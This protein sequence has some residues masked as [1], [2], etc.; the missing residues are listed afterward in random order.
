MK[1]YKK[2]LYRIAT[3]FLLLAMLIVQIQVPFLSHAAGPTITITVAD[4]SGLGNENVSVHVSGIGVRKINETSYTAEIG[5]MVYITA[6]SESKFFTGWSF[7]QTVSGAVLAN[8]STSFTAPSGDLTINPLSRSTTAADRGKVMSDS[9]KLNSFGD[10]YALQEMIAKTSITTAEISTY[11]A[12]AQHFGLSVTTTANYA[13]ARTQLNTGYFIVQSDVALTELNPDTGDDNWTPTKFFTGIGTAAAAFQGVIDGGGHQVALLINTQLSDMTSAYYTGLLGNAQGTAAKNAVIR[14][15]KVSGSIT[16][17]V[18]FGG[19]LGYKL[20]AGGLAGYVGSNVVLADCSSKANIMVKGTYAVQSTSAIVTVGGLAGQIDANV[21]HGSNLSYN[22]K[23]LSISAESN[24]LVYA[25]GCFGYANNTYIFSAT[26]E[27]DDSKVIANSS[28]QFGGGYAL[29]SAGGLAGYFNNTTAN[30]S[31]AISEVDVIS[32]GNFTI[33]ATIHNAAGKTAGNG[34]AGGLVGYI[35]VIGTGAVMNVTDNTIHA[36]SEGLIQARDLSQDS[37]SPVY[38]GGVF[39]YTQCTALQF[40]GDIFDGKIRVESVIYGKASSYAGGLAGYTTNAPSGEITLDLTDVHVK[41][42]EKTTSSGTIHSYVGG[43]FGAA[44]ANIALSGLTLTGS[45]ILISS[46]RDSGALSTGALLSGGIIGIKDGGSISNCRAL[47]IS[48]FINVLQESYLSSPAATDPYS[49]IYAGGI[50]GYFKSTGTLTN[51]V[52]AGASDGDGGYTGTGAQIMGTQNGIYGNHGISDGYIGGIAGKSNGEIRG[53][54]YYGDPGST[55]EGIILHSNNSANSPCVAGIVGLTQHN[56]IDCHVRNA[57]IFGDGYNNDASKSDTDIIVAGV[58]G[59][60]NGSGKK[61]MNCTVDG[62]RVEASGRDMTLTYAGGIVGAFFT[63][64]LTVSGC[65]FENGEVVG[66]GHMKWG[67][68]GGILGY[69]YDNSAFVVDNCFVINSN[70]SASSAGTDPLLTPYAAAGGFIGFVAP[71]NASTAKMVITNSFSNAHLTATHVDP[72]YVVTGGIVGYRKQIF[73]TGDNLTNTFYHLQNSGADV[74]L[75][76][77]PITNTVQATITAKAAVDFSTILLDALSPAAVPFQTGISDTNSEMVTAAGSPY[78]VTFLSGSEII[79]GVPYSLRYKF[80]AIPGMY[81]FNT[82]DFVA[83]IRQSNPDN[84]GATPTIVRRTFGTI[85]VVVTDETLPESTDISLHYDSE[86]GTLVETGINDTVQLKTGASGR[87][88]FAITENPLILDGTDLHL[89]NWQ[90]YDSFG[91]PIQPGALISSGVTI[92]I[93]NNHIS[94][95]PNKPISHR[96]TFSFQAASLTDPTLKTSRVTVNVDPIYVESVALTN[97]TSPENTNHGAIDSLGTPSNP[98]LVVKNSKLI[99]DATVYGE[100]GN[101]PTISSYAFGKEVCVSGIDGVVH[102]SSDGT[103][104]TGPFTGYTDAQL[105]NTVYKVTVKSIGEKADG[106]VAESR[107]IYIRLCVGTTVDKKTSGTLAAGLVDGSS[108]TYTVEGGLIEGENISLLMW[109]VDYQFSVAPEVGYGSV[110]DVYYTFGTPNAITNPYKKIPIGAVNST[111]YGLLKP[112]SSN[113]EYNFT[114][115]AD[116]ALTQPLYIM[117]KY[118]KV[119]GVLFDPNNGQPSLV[120][121]LPIGLPIGD[122]IP[123]VSFS[124]YTFTGWYTLKQAG[125]GAAYG[126]PLS[127]SDVVHAGVVYYARWQY[128]LTIINAA[129][130]LISGPVPFDKNQNFTFSVSQDAHAAGTPV[131]NV[132]IGEKSGLIIPPVHYTL[133]TPVYIVDPDGGA[134]AAEIVVTLDANGKQIHTVTIF[135]DYINKWINSTPYGIKIVGETISSSFIPEEAPSSSKDSRILQ[136][137]SFTLRYSVNHGASASNQ[138]ASYAFRPANSGITKD[139]AVQIVDKDDNP[140]QLPAGTMIRLHYNSYDDITGLAKQTVWSYCLPEAADHFQ[141]SAFSAIGETTAFRAET[142]GAFVASHS[143]KPEEYYF[144]VVPPYQDASL[145]TQADLAFNMGFV[146]D[147]GTIIQET[148]QTVSSDVAAKR[149]VS[150]TAEAQ[151]ALILDSITGG[152]L[153]IDITF[154]NQLLAANTPIDNRDAAFGVSVSFRNAEGKSVWL[155]AGSAIHSTSP[156]RTV[157]ST[158][159]FPV[160]KFYFQASDSTLDITIPP[161]GTDTAMQNE[162]KPLLTAAPGEYE[163]VIQLVS[164]RTNL[165]Y[166]NGNVLQTIVIPVTVS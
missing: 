75:G 30:A 24:E 98:L 99:L 94:I 14:N 104:F 19:T 92:S 33:S 74:A 82:T 97:A 120:V 93:T 16:V 153:S 10:F 64:S 151:G 70:L 163:M 126:N 106:H 105:A 43:F 113:Y 69:F 63:S 57:Y 101:H 140:T 77:T 17:D 50:V 37:S 134:F 8:T 13:T 62:S 59:L 55:N 42:V 15:I 159:T 6:V 117:V 133:G 136:D 89:V 73:L 108:G 80:A 78:E 138:P 116:P 25:G 130:Q 141:T 32:A 46:T 162:N 135:S 155:P 66:N 121:N 79:N 45:N 124:G 54:S 84:A 85:A 20:A 129:G 160:E 72:S 48:G 36:G 157:T 125:S 56:V 23:A 40:G 88:F 146:D 115:K 150:L 31:A 149:D 110:P 49:N 11:N 122:A 127:A 164:S 22:A 144:V 9:F 139:L 4:G 143:F 86:T 165:Q 53:C 61:I 2:Q 147:S 148:K 96:M 137:T 38:C 1:R 60:I 145:A 107:E 142:F 71:A 128:K 83:F 119:T 154:V 111:A 44:S 41:A 68:A 58:V 26:A 81:G 21:A 100:N 112:G 67:A 27:I 87:D 52:V 12:Y 39:G 65:I 34:Y 166:G 28:G 91:N 123:T 132:S 18:S 51:S 90:F 114:I 35:K 158:L 131:Y 95:V 29:A 109:N 3:T 156:D 152:T 161:M 76:G 47:I 103:V 7:S 102:V 118:Y 5:S